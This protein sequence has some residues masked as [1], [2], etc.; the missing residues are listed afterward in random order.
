MSD[1]MVRAECKRHDANLF[2][3]MQGRGTAMHICRVHCR[4]KVECR[5]WAND[6]GGWA[7]Q[8]IGGQWWVTRKGSGTEPVRQHVQAEVTYCTACDPSAP[9]LPAPLDNDTVACGCCDRSVGVDRYGNVAWHLP[10]GGVQGDPTC[11][12]TGRKP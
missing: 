2:N 3:T 8:T 5:L 11:P 12:G 6:R 10:P 1:W 7:R 4:V 9:S